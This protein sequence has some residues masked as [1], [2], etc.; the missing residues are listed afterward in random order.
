MAPSDAE[1]FERLLAEYVDRLN[2]GETLDRDAVLAD[3]AD[4]GEALLRELLTFEEFDLP[5]AAAARASTEPLGSLGDY[6]L[7]RQLG[8][9]GMGVVYEAWEGSMDRRVALK[10]LPAG[11][12]ADER[13]VSRFVREAQLA[14]RLQHPSIVSVYGMG[15]KDETPY[16]AMEY[17]EGETLAHVLWR[18]REA[19][20]EFETPF[21]RKDG[22][23]YFETLARAF[24]EVAEGLQHAHA[25]KVIHRDIK[26]SNL[27]LD[28]DRG[29]G[30]GGSGQGRLRILDFG[31][32][33]LE[34]QESLTLSGDLLGTPAYMSPEQAR[35]RKIPI[36][37]RTD[38]YSLG[39]TMYEAVAGRPPFRGKDHQDTLSQIIERDPAEPRKLNP[40]LPRDLE[41]IILK[42]LR[43]DA[44]D[45]YGTAEA[46]EQ[47]LR[48][49]A[50][51]DPIEAR[52]QARWERVV[53]RLWRRR[54]GVA[55]AV[56][57]LAAMLAAG[58]LYRDHRTRVR[59]A[60][61]RTMRA[62]V[63]R[64]YFGER[65]VLGGIP[66][67]S[68][69]PY[70]FSTAA[71]MMDR[72]V[73]DLAR[74]AT[75]LRDL[76][77]AH[78]HLAR[79]FAFR[80]A[81]D[82]ALAELDRA[83]AIDPGFAPALFW[84]AI[85]HWAGADIDEDAALP[86]PEESRSPWGRVWIEAHRSLLE[87]RSLD[88]AAALGRLLDLEEAEGGELYLGSSVELLLGR[89]LAW[90]GAGQPWL[91]YADFRAADLLW[92]GALE[93]PM[94]MGK[95]LLHA[96]RKDLAEAEFER[97][98]ERS[99]RSDFVAWSVE[100]VY[101][102]TFHGEP[103]EALEGTRRWAQKIREEG[104]TE[105]VLA[106]RLPD[107][108]LCDEATRLAGRAVA[109]APL[110]ALIW[111]YTAY[112]FSQ[113]GEGSRSREHAL[114]ALELDGENPVVVARAADILRLTGELEEAFK[115]AKRAI[116]LDRR[117][118][119]GHLVLG[120]V[121]SRLG[122]LDEAIAASRRAARL[123]P[124]D[125]GLPRSLGGFFLENGRHAEAAEEFAIA[126]QNEPRNAN[127]LRQFGEALEALG[128]FEEALSAYCRSVEA[129]PRRRDAW[130]RIAA[131]LLAQRHELAASGALERLRAPIEGALELVLAHDARRGPPVLGVLAVFAML[132]GRSS[133]AVLLLEEASRLPRAKRSLL[134]FLA[135]E[136]RA[137]LP[138]LPSYASVDAAL[139]A[140]GEDQDKVEA[141]AREFRA[142][143]GPEREA[144]LAYL[145]ARLLELAGE[146]DAA[147]ALFAELAA[148]EQAR[149][150]PLRRLVVCRRALGDLAGAE[151]ALRAALEGDALD[152]RELW[153][154][155]AALGFAE[156]G[157][158][159]AELLAS[160]PVASMPEAP[161][162]DDLR[163][164]LERLV[165]GDA[166]R[167]NAGG[168]DYVSPSSGLAWSRDRFFDG[169]RLFHDGQRSYA[170]DIADT[171]DG[172]LYQ[173]ERWFAADEVVPARYRIPLPRGRY[174][175][176]LH[177]AEI[178]H[179]QPG[180]RRFGVRV[181]GKVIIED[182][183]P[184]AVGFATADVLSCDGAA[185]DAIPVEDGILDIEFIARIDMPKVSA[186]E[187][188]RVE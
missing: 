55:M 169:G 84:R 26:P 5:Q 102:Y 45:R 151:Q 176:R 109:L 44:A 138:D 144:V 91:A 36:D 187:V 120:A 149:S 71:E 118:G 90:L 122:R 140:V 184:L 20:P 158:T 85:I 106:R 92:P 112:A 146:H 133:E 103:D 35:R 177:F 63:M 22:A 49:F 89:G 159:P 156:L 27:I 95:A 59:A 9:G 87:G 107:L 1:R 41:T 29:R 3:H 76:P 155:W 175:V 186:I 80:G 66:L 121:L 12:A 173:T 142:V 82:R 183:E 167:I 4:L 94:L 147:A 13:A 40:R 117:C 6:T 125:F 179:R 188:E 171:E 52:P 28:L 67:T 185:G 111:D 64:L 15:V 136:R 70:L 69:R 8:R 42:C 93:P 77:A 16:Y 100:I 97:A 124:G 39:A 170:G 126:V 182:Y 86:R 135:E 50:R 11:I 174:G 43:K 162:G 116:D 54:L 62:A 131:L 58:L 17:V 150:E 123:H 65:A 23:A 88:A 75:A 161:G 129:Q 33:R 108:G 104:L 30:E 57:A 148:G 172:A 72:A 113:C 119:L 68:T 81:D 78:Y 31:L 132:D 178:W 157:K 105:A 79:G 34:G 19:P 53:K 153:L 145:E 25:K 14:G 51:G 96:G 61:E 10:V 143:A 32:A 160:M 165:A 164:L 60:S 2:A 99:G 101:I 141:L 38:V 139:A 48:R 134:D 83:L 37:H 115:L 47:D 56:L 24:A 114:R 163:W 181:E 74:A 21:G 110:D 130:G 73:D 127:S 137:A 128:R 46:L 98:H 168:D 152:D 166:L 18:I 180:K 154:D 7:R